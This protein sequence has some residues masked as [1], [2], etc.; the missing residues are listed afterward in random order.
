[1]FF[2]YSPSKAINMVCLLLCGLVSTAYSYAAEGPVMNQ[3]YTV[4]GVKYSNGWNDYDIP[5]SAFL[6]NATEAVI[7][8]L[9]ARYVMFKK[10]ENGN[11]TNLQEYKWNDNQ[12]SATLTV[13]GDLLSAAQNGNICFNSDGNANNKSGDP[14]ILVTV[15]NKDANYVAPTPGTDPVNPG[16]DPVNPGTP[17]GGNDQ[18]YTKDRTKAF[19]YEFTNQEL[20]AY[21]QLTDVPTVYI[22]V[23]APDDYS[24][25]A[26]SKVN[27]KTVTVDELAANYS[28]ADI[29]T[30]TD[31]KYEWYY[32]AQ[33]IIHDDQGTIKERNETVSFRGR[34]NSTWDSGS[35]KK[36]FRLKFQSKTA[37]LTERDAATGQ[38]VNNYADNKSWT[39]LSNVYDK[40]LFRNA[41][42]AELGKRAG[43]TFNP[44]YKFVDLVVNGTQL[45]TYQISDQMNADPMRVNVD[46]KT[47][48]FGEFCIQRMAEDPYVIA[49]AN[50]NDIY[51]SFKNPEA[52]VVTSS[53]PTT[54]PK[55]AVIKD[56]YTQYLTA[57]FNKDYAS[58]RNQTDLKSLV[59]WMIV[60]DLSG[61][62][63]GAMANVYTYKDVVDTKLKFGPLW[64]LDIAYGN[65]SQLDGTH[66]WNAQG[67]GCGFLFAEMYKD[68]YFVKALYEQWTKF[69]EGDGLKNFVTQTVNTFSKKMSKSVN[70]NYS[71]TAQKGFYDWD[72][73]WDLGKDVSWCT[74]GVSS[75]DAATKAVTDYINNR[76]TWLEKEYSYQYKELKCS[77]L[78]CIEHKYEEG[79]Y[80]ASGNGTY[81]RLCDNCD[82]EDTNSTFYKYTT[83]S[84]GAEAVT[85]YTSDRSA[86]DNQMSAITGNTIIETDLEGKT[87][88]NIVNG[89]KCEK[90][91]LSDDEA[92]LFAGTK[93]ST[94]DA[95]YTRTINASSQWGT[96]CLPYRIEPDEYDDYE[97]YTISTIEG[98]DDV[99]VLS[100]IVSA[101]GQEPAFFRK[102][103]A[104]ATQITF[105]GKAKAGATDISVKVYQKTSKNTGT[106]EAEGWTLYGSLDNEQS[107]PAAAN[108]Y[109]LNGDTFYNATEAFTLK[110]FRAYLSAPASV[111]PA[112]LR[113][114]VA[115]ET[116]AIFN[117]L[118]D[119]DAAFVNQKSSRQ[120]YD[121]MGRRVSTTAKH[122][123][124]ISEDGKI[125]RK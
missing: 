11:K 68:P 33:I 4:T 15:L 38:T 9:N 69:K 115:D 110:P 92:W 100:P 118:P 70:L 40:T 10:K 19:G 34:G 21:P 45:G 3:V 47:G 104:S 7:T 50:W 17:D 99:L 103:D 120:A 124:Y 52:D 16:T 95:T 23:Y 27:V 1:M 113:M 55:F 123:F 82:E 6:P 57:L 79:K 87:G 59:A 5:A 89:G 73:A 98:D 51:V 39:L 60:E 53:G 125:V 13:T 41:L 93:F 54:D 64:D 88:K 83:Y 121:L 63:D 96:I 112:A 43:L 76:I 80:V 84:N 81:H 14:N 116:N 25:G 12:F 90:L 101:G 71:L 122:G 37:L 44:A 65:Y 29:S 26:Y 114:M 106:Q 36:P 75:Y 24:T 66:F 58:W 48:W 20:N 22:N 107:I 91:V 49:K 74:K 102:K 77:S 46:S 85:T 18:E 86:L 56:W 109:Y 30:I 78:K 97:L 108:N 35:K 42:S 31:K 61:N 62:F 67:Q 105:K 32:Q 94:T 8:V 2:S 117:I 28:L 119:Q 111:N 72:P